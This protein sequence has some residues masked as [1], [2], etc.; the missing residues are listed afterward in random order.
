[1]L[2][3]SKESLDVNIKCNFTAK[4]AEEKRHH[5]E[6]L[7]RQQDDYKRRV[8]TLR[9]EL[10]QLQR[11]HKG[12]TSGERSPSPTTMKFIEQNHHLQ[13]N[14]QFLN[15]AIHICYILS[16]LSLR[17]YTFVYFRPFYVV[18]SREYSWLPLIFVINQ[19]TKI[20]GNLVL[21]LWSHLISHVIFIFSFDCKITPLETR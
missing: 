14:G 18:P 20:N 8:A 1:M 6:N 15:F 2:L 13:V 21:V 4:I 7:I 5:V 17:K 10:S 19:F 3:L 11:Q 12:L 16:V 9:H